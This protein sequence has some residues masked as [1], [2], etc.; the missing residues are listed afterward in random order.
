MISVWIPVVPPKIDWTRLSPGSSRSWR[1]A[2]D[3][4]SRRP[5]R[6]PF[7]QRGPWR[8]RGAIWAAITRHGIVSPRRSSPVRGVAPTTT[9]NQR[10]RISQ[11][12]MRTSRPVSS[13]R[14]SC[15]RSS[16]CTMPATAARW[17]R[18]PASRRAAIRTSAGV[19]TL[20]PT[21]WARAALDD[22]RDG[23]TAVRRAASGLGCGAQNAPR[24]QPGFQPGRR[25]G[26]PLPTIDGPQ[27]AG[28]DIP[29]DRARS[30]QQAEATADDLRHD[31]DGAA[32]PCSISDAARPASLRP[33]WVAG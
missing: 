16:G 1:R 9:P 4:C 30:G 3:W 8:S 32:E 13:S 24:G 26:P 25:H 11:P 27:A 22:H 17:G 10:P 5:R 33:A 21:A 19:R 2:A 12:S 23:R 14:H 20:T 18:A 28:P 6:A 29:A 31:L 7:S 15:H